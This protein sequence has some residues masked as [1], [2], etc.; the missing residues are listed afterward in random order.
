[1]SNP[2]HSNPN[3]QTPR[4]KIEI[5][6]IENHL[7]TEHVF[8]VAGLAG[9]FRSVV[10]ADELMAFVRKTGKYKDVAAPDL[11]MLDF[12]LAASG[13]EILA[14]PHLAEIPVVVFGRSGTRHSS[15][16]AEQELLHSETERGN[17]VRPVRGG[18][19]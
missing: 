12:S 1:M 15:L 6:V 18:L 7:L 9:A 2:S 13:R 17:A 16:R 8:R 14:S 4:R 11:I 3:F 5:F 10:D 19:L